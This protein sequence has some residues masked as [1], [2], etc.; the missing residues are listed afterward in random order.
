M[1]F[2]RNKQFQDFRGDFPLQFHCNN[3]LLFCYFFNFPLPDTK[4]LPRN[5]KLLDDN[6]FTME[7]QEIKPRNLTDEIEESM[8]EAEAE[9]MPGPK[10]ISEHE[11]ESI[12]ENPYS[13]RIYHDFGGSII[14]RNFDR[15]TEETIFQKIGKR[16]WSLFYLAIGI[17]IGVT[18]TLSMHLPGKAIFT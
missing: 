6:R 7:L 1:V 15:P 18:V 9:V 17:L 12:Y 3:K 2:E 8:S 5:C 10:P 13:T 11:S 16:K 14:I 4:N